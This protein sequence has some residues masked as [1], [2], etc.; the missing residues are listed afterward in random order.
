M[1]KSRFTR[2]YYGIDSIFCH[3]YFSLLKLDGIILSADDF[4]TVDDQYKFDFG[5]LGEAHEWNQQRG[6]Y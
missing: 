4:F 6:M 3:L 5:K 2:L 1:I